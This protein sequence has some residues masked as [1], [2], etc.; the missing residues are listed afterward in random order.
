VPRV[1]KVVAVAARAGATRAHVEAATAGLDRMARMARAHL[2]D[3]AG[4]LHDGHEPRRRGARD[5]DPDWRS[6]PPVHP[7]HIVARRAERQVLVV[8]G[9]LL[10]G[11]RVPELGR[12][13]KLTDAE[14]NLLLKR[15]GIGRDRDRLLSQEVARA[16]RRLVGADRPD[17]ALVDRVMDDAERA[18]R[19]ELRI[20]AKAAVRDYRVTA[21]GWEPETVLRWEARISS[22]P[23]PCPSC[24]DRHGREQTWAEW[25]AEGEPGNANT[26]CGEECLCALDAV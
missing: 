18:V 16:S 12:L 17:A 14:L 25:Q 11:G 24:I 1:A 3:V 19:A 2:V 10:K 26:L 23:K 6:Y 8:D 15:F 20:S 5:L 22:T 4:D 7:G 9:P 13:G 21:G